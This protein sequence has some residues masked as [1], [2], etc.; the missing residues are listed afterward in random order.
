VRRDFFDL[1]WREVSAHDLSR[2]ALS[3]RRGK[4][5]KHGKNDSKDHMARSSAKNGRNGTTEV[6]RAVGRKLRL[7]RVERGFTLQA[8]AER[9]GVSAAMLSLVERGK[10][11]PSVGTLVA[12]NSLLNL[13]IP[14]LLGNTSGNQDPVTP[15]RKQ[16]VVKPLRGVTHRVIADDQSR[17]LQMTLNHYS[18]GSANSPEPITHGGF[19]YGYVLDGELEVTV[20]GEAHRL[21]PGDLIS[22]WSSKPHR[23]VNRGRK[24]ASALWIN[25]RTS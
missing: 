24:K 20:D 23:I 12:I 25:L 1:Y 5:G 11:S 19:E 4:H 7:R 10:A 15:A 2:R 21:R 16:T 14:E 22:Y 9:T 17:G 6:L 8:V 3:D 13:H 18:R